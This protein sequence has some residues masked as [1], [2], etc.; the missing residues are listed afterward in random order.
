LCCEKR[1][2][3]QQDERACRYGKKRDATAEVLVHPLHTSTLPSGKPA[4]VTGAS[5]LCKQN[6]FALERLLVVYAA[7]DKTPQKKVKNDEVAAS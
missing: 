4:R 6:V 7:H 5:S 2:S 3:P 1:D